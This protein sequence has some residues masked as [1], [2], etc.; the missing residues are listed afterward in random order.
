MDPISP[1]TYPLISV[2][3]ATYNGERFIRQQLDSI[4]G[5]TY[6]NLELIVTD[7]CSTDNT[8]GILQEYASKDSRV[9]VYRNEVNLGY[10]KN[11]EKGMRLSTGQ[12]MAPSDQDDIWLPEKLSKLYREMGAHRIVYC[13]SALINS[14]GEKTGKLL[15]DIKRLADFDDCLMYAIGNSAPGHAMLLTRETAEASFP[16]PDMIPHDH[17]LSF[18]AT[19]DSSLKFIPEPLVLYRQHDGNVFG[20]VRAADGKKRKKKK[21]G[22]AVKNEQIRRR[23]ALM[24]EKCPEQ[25]PYQKRFFSLMHKSYAS[26]SLMNNLTRVRIFFQNRHK[27]LSFKR[28]PEWRRWLFCI[29]MFWSIQ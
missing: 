1:A 25:L 24:Y 4:L 5:Q 29:K 18:V 14:N 9:K 2:I 12:L 6:P 19:F 21:P 3:I 28:R 26:F 10:V 11:F 17:W 13:N 27:I 23:V 22:R 20:A 16:L 15:S 7:D 8:P